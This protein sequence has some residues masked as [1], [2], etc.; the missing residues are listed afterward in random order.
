[1]AVC[2]G[3]LFRQAVEVVVVVADFLQRAGAVDAGQGF[4][5]FVFVEVKAG[6]L[7]AMLLQQTQ[8]VPGEAGFSQWITVGVVLGFFDAPAQRVVGHPDHAAVVIAHFDQSAFGVVTEA[9]HAPFSA[10]FFDHPAE[11]VVAVT[12]VLI[13]QQFVV[14]H[15]PGAGLRAVQQVGGGVVGEGFALAVQAVLAGD[16]AAIGIIGFVGGIMFMSLTLFL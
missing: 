8:A 15:Q 10:A 4:V 11:G 12:F 1:M 16:D 5:A 6:L 14:H 7:M 9:L 2:L 13:G 3:E